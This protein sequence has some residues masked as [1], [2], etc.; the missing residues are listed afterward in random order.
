MEDPLLLKSTPKVLDI[1]PQGALHKFLLTHSTELVGDAKPAQVHA[2]SL[3]VMNHDTCVFSQLTE[4]QWRDLGQY[5]QDHPSVDAGIPSEE[6]DNDRR[7]RPYIFDVQKIAEVRENIKSTTSGKKIILISMVVS[8]VN[9]DGWISNQLSDAAAKRVVKV[10]E[11]QTIANNHAW[12]AY[13]RLYCR[14]SESGILTTSPLAI[15]Y[16][17]AILQI[18]TKNDMHYGITAC[19]A[20]RIDG[21]TGEVFEGPLTVT[22]YERLAHLFQEGTRGDETAVDSIHALTDLSLKKS[23]H[24]STLSDQGSTDRFVVLLSVKECGKAGAS[25]QTWSSL[26][27]S[28]KARIA[29]TKVECPTSVSEGNR[30]CDMQGSMLKHADCVYLGLAIFDML[31]NDL[32]VSVQRYE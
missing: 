12:T 19:N 28:I 27:E 25:V 22:E 11:K 17:Q 21:K 30:V 14:P 7:C 16:H 5:A 9:M 13:T 24:T 2:A 23:E 8:T 10:T 26:N 1:N 6:T 32:A 18:S 4:S 29:R 20:V 31:F 15:S 3:W